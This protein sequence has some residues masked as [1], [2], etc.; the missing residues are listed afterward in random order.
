MYATHIGPNII[1]QH[2]VNI[3]LLNPQSTYY[4]DI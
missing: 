4:L 3:C 1:L 2:D